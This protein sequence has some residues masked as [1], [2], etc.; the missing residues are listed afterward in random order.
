MV[1]IHVRGDG[2]VSD[3]VSQLIDE[4]TFFHMIP[5]CSN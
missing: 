5:F 3:D 1:K 2:L 4:I